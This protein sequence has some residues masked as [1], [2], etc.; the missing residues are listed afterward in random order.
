[1]LTQLVGVFTAVLGMFGDI[2][3]ALFTTGESAGALSALLPYFLIGIAAS[4]ILLAARV[5]RKFVW[6]N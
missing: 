2:V 4:L 6:G 5:I 3:S 1:M